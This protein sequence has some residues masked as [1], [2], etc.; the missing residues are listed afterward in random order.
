MTAVAAHPKIIWRGDTVKRPIARGL[1][2]ISI[3]TVINGPAR[4]PLTTAA[5]YSARAG[6][7]PIPFK[8]APAS[9]V[10]A[11]VP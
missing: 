7:M 11:I 8:D 5:Q 2:T 3:I 9:V 6:S 10:A 4:M 1:R